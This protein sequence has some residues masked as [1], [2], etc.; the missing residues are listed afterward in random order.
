MKFSKSDIAGLKAYRY[1]GI[2]K[3]LIS[4]YFLN[5]YWWSQLIKIFPLWFAPNLITLSGLGFVL[6]NL[7]TLLWKA[8]TLEE[9]CEWWVYLSFGVGLFLYQSFDAIDG[10][11][12]RRTGTSGP[13][14][15]VQH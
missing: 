9:E 15:E 7:A 10:K 1:S 3:S 2:D 11:Q 13:L 8:P 12:A 5:P 4:V 14:G 6:I